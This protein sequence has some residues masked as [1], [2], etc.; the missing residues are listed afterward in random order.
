MQALIKK[1]VMIGFSL[2]PLL[3]KLYAEADKLSKE[4]KIH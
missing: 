1:R 4:K 2:L 3:Q